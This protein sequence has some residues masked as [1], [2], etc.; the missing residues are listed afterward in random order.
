MPQDVEVRDDVIQKAVGQL[1][2]VV[3]CFR[4][5]AFAAAFPGTWSCG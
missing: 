1:H 5:A 3:V 4:V 2:P